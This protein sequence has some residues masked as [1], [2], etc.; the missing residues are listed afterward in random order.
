MWEG[1]KNVWGEG[2]E[3]DK[4][5]HHLHPGTAQSA[6][7]W[8]GVTARSTSHRPFRRPAIPAHLHAVT[9]REGRVVVAQP[10]QTEGRDRN[11]GTLVMM[12][13]EQLRLPPSCHLDT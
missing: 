13:K 4:T 12:M 10:A 6:T 1:G 2:M 3:G 9:I 8:A 11:E 5:D 7:L